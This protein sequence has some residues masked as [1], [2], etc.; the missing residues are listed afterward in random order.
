VES[1]HSAT[2]GEFA[3]LI[4]GYFER[5]LCISL[6]IF[7]ITSINGGK[8]SG[9]RVTNNHDRNLESH[10]SQTYLQFT[11]ATGNFWKQRKN[12]ARGGGNLSKG[13][14]FS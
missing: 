11:I 7:L 2:S 10:D 8:I 5:F 1:W 6:W 3:Q 9:K 14:N 4:S 12:V 13:G